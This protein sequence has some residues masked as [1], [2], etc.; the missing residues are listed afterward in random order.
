MQLS[1][2]LFIVFF[3]LLL[4]TLWRS[5]RLLNMYLLNKLLL[6]LP[7]YMWKCFIHFLSKIGENTAQRV[8]LLL[9]FVFRT[10]CAVKRSCVLLWTAFL[11]ASLYVKVIYSFFE[12]P[13]GIRNNKKIGIPIGQIIN[14]SNDQ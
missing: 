13:V 9:L 5:S 11:V 14:R 10:L 1:E 3:V 7:S 12:G 4:F 8:V 2:E 6:L